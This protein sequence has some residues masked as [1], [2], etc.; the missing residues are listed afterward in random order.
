M[1]ALIL[2]IILSVISVGCACCV[3]FTKHP[4]YAA[5][6]LVTTMLSLAG[7]YGL[8]GSPFVG[9]VQVMV[10]AGAVMTLL[11]FII[12]VLNG[13]RDNRTKRFDKTSAFVIVA[14][15]L[16]AVV[17]AIALG[18]AAIGFDPET[19]RG[20]VAVTAGTLFD[21]CASG[22]GYY[23]IVLSVGLILLSAMA[24]A[25]I[26]ARKRIASDP[27]EETSEEVH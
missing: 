11:M 4:L 22:N 12:M 5:L 9:V 26:L 19:V 15:L 27:E 16:L 13:A 2:F 10:Y 25:V 24:T 1:L 7:I 20:S 14:A 21:M 6:A 18:H 17:V 3:F 8:L 23:L